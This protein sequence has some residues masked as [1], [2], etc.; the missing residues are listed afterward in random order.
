MATQ[1]RTA[2]ATPRSSGMN[3]KMQETLTGYLFVSPW[4]ISALV[5]TFG[6]M[7][8]VFYLSFTDLQMLNTPKV[9]GFNN[10]TKILSD[11]LFHTAVFNT[12]LYSIV[13]TFCQTWLAL[14]LAVV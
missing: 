2:A 11:P 6:A 12:V 4:I 8:Y 10:Y 9:T 13:V 14:I 7:A 1:V 5:F 3:R